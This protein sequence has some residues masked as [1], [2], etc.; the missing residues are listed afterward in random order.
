MFA[1]RLNHQPPPFATGVVGL[2]PLQFLVAHEAVLGGPVLRVGR[3]VAI[4]FIRPDQLEFFR[5]PRRFAV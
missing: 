3:A 2:I 5:G 1:P 4:E